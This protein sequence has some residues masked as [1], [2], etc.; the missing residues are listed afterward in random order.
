[1]GFHG[2]GPATVDMLKKKKQ[3]APKKFC[4]LNQQAITSHDWTLGKKGFLILV[5][6]YERDGT[7]YVLSLKARENK[8][9][10]RLESF[11]V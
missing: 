6:F 9:S 11:D 2:Q 5:V 4:Q 10:H 8:I 1:M 3:V 7:I